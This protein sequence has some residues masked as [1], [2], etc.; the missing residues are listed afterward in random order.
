LLDHDDSA[1]AALDEALTLTAILVRAPHG[2]VRAWVGPQCL[3][4]LPEDVT[5]VRE[6]PLPDGVA[7]MGAIPVELDLRVGARLLAVNDPRTLQTAASTERLPF[8]LAARPGTVVVPASTN[9]AKAEGAYLRQHGI[10][11]KQ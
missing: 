6:I 11:R 1:V 8:A 5:A 3:D 10:S 9:Y 2:R 4:L 7:F